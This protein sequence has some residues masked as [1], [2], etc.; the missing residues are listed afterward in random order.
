[1]NVIARTPKQLGTGLRRY[2]RQRCLTQAQLGE[3]MKARQAT[4]SKLESGQPATQL[5][6]LMSALAALDLELTIR[7]RTK[8]SATEIEDLF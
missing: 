2:R 5:S 3:L 7:P 8:V 1:M 6:I 4:V